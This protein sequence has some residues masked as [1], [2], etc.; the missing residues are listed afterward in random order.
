VRY[1]KG[2]E[3]M[4]TFKFM[5]KNYEV[6]VDGFLINPAQWDE[7]FAEGM[8]PM[9]GIA[10]K[11]NES[12]WSVI[13]FIRDRVSATGLSPSVYQVCKAHRL[14]LAGLR[15]LFPSGYL[16]GACKLAG[17]TYRQDP[18]QPSWLPRERLTR[19][20]MPPDNRIYRVDIRGFLVDHSE[21]DEEYAVYKSLE[22]KMPEGLT[23]EHWEIIAFLRKRF[24]KDGKV[25]TVYETCEAHQMEIEDLERLFPD[26]YHRG[27]LKIAG[28]RA[29]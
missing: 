11:L 25:P 19:V 22:L 8:A 15:S 13:S 29:R 28:L 9:V 3:I 6:D 24:E 17:L 26:G 23:E 10:E 27:T 21:W 7:S 16:R 4:G 1:S 12:H 2:E 20:S 5:N 18:F 14:H